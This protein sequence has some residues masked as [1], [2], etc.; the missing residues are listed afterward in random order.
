MK[1][2]GKRS[3]ALSLATVLFAHPASASSSSSAAILGVS[4]AVEGL[5]S[6]SQ[7]GSRTSLPTCATSTYWSIDLSSPGG[8]ATMA[9]LISAYL[10]N[11]P[12]SVTG[13]GTCNA[14]GQ[15]FVSYISF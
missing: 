8:P 3:F 6:F 15:E 13:T 10:S 12:I 2:C 11:K 14:Y 4:A 9:A 5:G 1:I 7:S